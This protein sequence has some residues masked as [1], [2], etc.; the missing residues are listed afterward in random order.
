MGAFPDIAFRGCRGSLRAPQVEAL[1]QR[2]SAGIWIAFLIGRVVD[3]LHWP[4]IL[5]GG[6]HNSPPSQAYYPIVPWFKSMMV[7]ELVEIPMRQSVVGYH[8]LAGSSCGSGRN[9]GTGMVYNDNTGFI[10]SLYRMM[11]AILS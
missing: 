4:M 8:A 9:T 7:G 2:I 3:A 1:S 6:L 11:F 10:L 5:I